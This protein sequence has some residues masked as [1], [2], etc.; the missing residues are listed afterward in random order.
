MSTTCLY[1]GPIIDSH[2]HL[3]NADRAGGIPWPEAGN[4]LHGTYLPDRYWDL[5]SAQVVGAVVIE[6]SPWRSDNAWILD[7]VRNDPRILGVIGN[8]SPLDDH[9]SQD[10]DVLV[11]D[12]LFLGLRYGNLWG[13]DFSN[14]LTRPGFV[15]GLQ[16]LVE[17]DLTFESANPDLALVTD[18]LRL[19]DRLPDLRIVIDHLPNAQV[20]AH[21][22]GQWQRTLLE[23]AARPTVFSKWS[24][25]PQ[26]GPDGL[27]RDPAH[28]ADWL[29]FLR[30]AFGDH[31]C[32]FGS[33]W[34]N[35]ESVAN[36]EDTLQ[37]T[38]ACINGLSKDAQTQ[39]FAGNF[40]RAY[41]RLKYE[42][43]R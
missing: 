37:L 4:P 39:F 1:D 16:G 14:D 33:D 2:I 43:V 12:P 38:M 7:T 40:A 30:E 19:S 31:R 6:A 3:Y 42:A 11:R 8:L 32:F 35:S 36:F 41:Q 17:H 23:L 5:V 24:E 9:F 26:H 20:P 21:L 25:V 29:G 22:A 10:F 34:P 18:L 28:Y 27:I 13:R 15:A